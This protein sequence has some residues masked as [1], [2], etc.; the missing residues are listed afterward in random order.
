MSPLREPLL[1]CRAIVPGYGGRPVCP[2]VSFRIGPGDVLALAGRNGAGKTTLLLTCLGLIPP[3]S[4]SVTLAGHP[5][6]PMHLREKARRVAYVPQREAAGL[7]L[8]AAEFVATGRFAHSRGLW[9]DG[10]DRTVI[11]RA[12][13]W[14]GVEDCRKPVSRFSGGERQRLSLARAMAQEAPVILM[15]EPSTHLDPWQKRR[16]GKAIGELAAEGK[17]VVVVSHDI[18]W[19]RDL[20]TVAVGIS[21]GGVRTGHPQ[22]ILGAEHEQW[23]FGG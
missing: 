7:D 20:A 3:V 11:E 4:G 18:H 17:A 1:E 14:A 23:L 16:L 8:S 13:R 15:D 6:G 10:A 21:A 12:L 22:E 5:V 2:S 19:C 9:E